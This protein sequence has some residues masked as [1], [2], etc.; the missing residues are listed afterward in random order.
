MKRPM[1][2]KL[3]QHT[4]FDEQTDIFYIDSIKFVT[5]TKASM[6][7]GVIN[8]DDVTTIR[9]FFTVLL[10][11]CQQSCIVEL[12]NNFLAFWHTDDKFY[13]FQTLNAMHKSSKCIQLPSFDS[14]QLYLQKFFINTESRGE[15][16]FY[17][18]DFLKINDNVFSREEILKNFHLG[19]AAK[20]SA[21]ES[22]GSDNIPHKTCLMPAT[23]DP[24][25][26]SFH[27]ITEEKYIL[28]CPKTIDRVSTAQLRTVSCSRRIFLTH[29]PFTRVERCHP[30]ALPPL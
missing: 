21:N 4:E 8:K 16:V 13:M 7:T 27:E 12:N 22:I 28:R 3:E 20:V 1:N 29:F 9:D 25:A 19:S 2:V 17:T 23:Y 11:S 18:V 30:R 10:E 24:N 14:V 6:A 26:T 15:Y 5:L